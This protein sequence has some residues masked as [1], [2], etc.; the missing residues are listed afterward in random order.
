MGLAAMRVS[1]I[2]STAACAVL[3]LLFVL[4]GFAG[5][6]AAAAPPP[7]P[8]RTDVPS[9][10]RHDLP[11]LVPGDKPTDQDLGHAFFFADYGYLWRHIPWDTDRLSDASLDDLGDKDSYLKGTVNH[12]LSRWAASTKRK[13]LQVRLGRQPWLNKTTAERQAEMRRVFEAWLHKTLKLWNSNSVGLAFQKYYGRFAGLTEA[14]GW[15]YEQPYPGTR[16]RSRPEY[17][18]QRPADSEFAYDE[19]VEC[20]YSS[21]VANLSVSQLKKYVSHGKGRGG[22]RIT[23]VVDDASPHL[24]DDPA[25]GEQLDKI[26]EVNRQLALEN[27]KRSAK[28]EPAYP[29]IRVVQFPATGV[30]YDAL[31]GDQIDPPDPAGGAAAQSEPPPDTSPSGAL[32]AGD[33]QQAA[34]AVTD[35]VAQAPASAREAAE[36][37]AFAKE[38]ARALG[39]ADAASAEMAQGQ[40]GGVDFSSLELRYLADTAGEGGTGVRY[41]YRVDPARN[42]KVSYGGRQAAQLAADSFFTWLV[43]PPESFTVNLNPDEPDRIIDE[44]LGATDA[45]RV[46]LEADLR[47]KKS[48]AKLIHPDTARGKAFWNSLR[49]ETRCLPMRQWIVPKPAVV[50]DTGDELF[51]ID[52]PLEVKSETTYVKATGAG[53]ASGCPGQADSDTRHNEGVYQRQVTPLVEKAVNNAPEYADLRRV[54]ASRV[55]AEWYRQRSQNN[56]TTYGDL[57][58][59]GDATPWPA[60]TKWR[61]RQ[62]FDRYVDTYRNGEF[63]VKHT[64]RRGNVIYTDVYTYGGVD[65]TTIPTTPL[66]EEQ[67]AAARPTLPAAIEASVLRPVAES[68]KP[69]VWLGGRSAQRP[70][71][72][73]PNGQVVPPAPPGVQDGQPVEFA[74]EATAAGRFPVGGSQV[75][76]L[77]GGVAVLLILIVSA[78]ARRRRGRK[79][80]W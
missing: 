9:G 77:A 63:K 18:W 38:T 79:R 29:L 4:Q 1:G 48:V 46:L 62:V 55:A 23:Y 43:L 6:L 33:Q 13:A 26:A 73:L 31:S 10:P 71:T 67:F 16:D 21:T 40:L 66:S 74:S 72:V 47:M 8:G 39:Y 69:D 51:I 78:V 68:G 2:R 76:W 56:Q 50:R 65:L 75:W 12:L 36:D 22:V 28:G 35:T 44:R 64:T 60:R 70:L 19:Q 58:D 3:V 54:Y 61:P 41:A 52:A 30:P 32:G 27:E 59:S 20:K 24:A 7:A 57:V 11:G 53:G 37:A 17:F 45:G 42:V 25:V 34:S 5:V 15:A 80:G 49:G 14:A